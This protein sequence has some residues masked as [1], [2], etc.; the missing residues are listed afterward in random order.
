MKW[1]CAQI[2]VGLLL[3]TT[4]VAFAQSPPSNAIPV[5]ADNFIRAYSDVTFGNVVKDDGFGK[6]THNRALTPIEK[7][8]VERQNRDTLYSVAIF[9]LDAGPV[10]ITLPDP[11]ARFMSVQVIDEDH[12]TSAVIYKP[13][14]Y[15]FTRDNIGTR[16][17]LAAVRVLVDPSKPEDLERAHA[18]QDAIKVSQASPGRF[19]APNWD[20]SSLKK[21]SDALKVLGSTTPD[22]KNMFGT[23]EQVTPVR[24]LIGT[25]IAWGGNPETEA[26]YL[27]VTPARNDGKT[28]HMLTVRDV[29]VDGFW[30]INVYNAKGFFEPN[31]QNAYSLNEITATKAKDGSIN[32]QFGDCDGRIPNCLPITPG[33]NYIVRLYRPSAE[34]LNGKWKFPEAHAAK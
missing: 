21:V 10:T 34:I 6:F 33:W 26:T 25:A 17:V 18:V 7:Q 3:T 29:P 4:L 30:S 31:P 16:Y 24:H 5:T 1:L 8:L 23:R 32:V 13:G 9:D 19:E 2:S 14:S 27:N 22:S 15:T 20:A 28:V 12:F 11:G